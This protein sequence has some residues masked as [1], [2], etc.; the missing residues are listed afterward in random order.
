MAVYLKAIA[1]DDLAPAERLARQSAA[2]NATLRTTC[3][4]TML[5]GGHA[6]NAL[7]QTAGA[8]VNCRILPGQSAEEVQ[9]KLKQ[10]I[11]DEQVT[12]STMASFGGGPPSAMR[13]DVFQAA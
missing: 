4:A 11:G 3:V 1:K 2:W 10:L 9:Q 8:L 12:I 13:D 5:D 7:P 6:Q